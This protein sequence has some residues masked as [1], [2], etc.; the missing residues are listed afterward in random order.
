MS[1][2]E[3]TQHEEPQLQTDTAAHTSAA[4]NEA[5]DGKDIAPEHNILDMLMQQVEAQAA[6]DSDTK[7]TQTT[8]GIEQPGPAEENSKLVHAEQNADVRM[9]TVEAQAAPGSGADVPQVSDVS[10]KP[11]SAEVSKAEEA[12]QDADV[13][14][15]AIETEAVERIQSQAVA[16][17]RA[18]PESNESTTAPAEPE[19]REWETDSSPY[20]SSDSDTS[21]DDS[22]SDDDSDDAEGDY[23]MMDPEEAARILMDDGGSDD[24]GKNKDNA[25]AGLRTNNERVEEVVPKPDVTVTQDMQIEELGNVEFVVEN[26]VVVKAKT[27][28]EYRVLESG[29]VLCLKD[30]SVIGVVAETIGRVEQPMYT[31][32]F[33]NEE[34]IKE[35]GVFE[36]GISIYYVEQHST[37]VFTQPLKG[38]K[39]SDASNIHDEEIGDDEMEFSDDEKEAEHKRQIKLRRQGRKDDGGRGGRGRGRGGQQGGGRLPSVPETNGNIS[40]LDYDDS[41][42]GYTPLSRP[43]NLH[44]MMGAAEPGEIADGSH[45]P[46]QNSNRGGSFQNSRGGRGR[47]RNN[48]GGRGGAFQSRG[49]LSQSP[50]TQNQNVYAQNQPAYAQ[51]QPVPFP[52]PTGQ[53]PPFQGSPP[54]PPQLN[55]QGSSASFP[56]MPFSPSPISPLPNGA[57]N[58]QPGGQFPN[59]AGMPP[60]PPPPAM[61][62]FGQ[63]GQQNFNANQM[64]FAQVQRQLEEMQRSQQQGGR[65]G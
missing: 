4:V 18:V 46:R 30:R 8:A 56:N 49:G 17:S 55:P 13:D 37:F 50:Y 16:E 2:E 41:G 27:S 45:Q 26:T 64:A 14:M 39:G 24:E 36:K 33:T 58:F 9:A 52:F 5:P 23:A 7:V 60:P 47:G 61:F 65:Q 57:F 28:G 11:E 1:P 51:N 29:S 48:R 62:N 43:T 40:T 35:A 59:F 20:E 10:G 12:E 63:P 22:S 53:Y 21:S 44:E 19:A 42:E 6:S 3:S 34:A 15:A 38:I 32:R 25:G 31:V 54:A